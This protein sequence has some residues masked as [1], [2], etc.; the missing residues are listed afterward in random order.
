MKNDKDMLDKYKERIKRQN[1]KIKEDYDR[2]SATLPK[3]TIERIKALG[4]TINGVI[5]DSVLSFLEYAE[6]TQEQ[7]TQ[8]SSD[9]LEDKPNPV[10]EIEDMEKLQEYLEQLRKDNEQRKQVEKAVDKAKIENALEE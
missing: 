9:S 10:H 8:P 5:N 7:L 1:N 4:L 3:G 6:Q 2:V